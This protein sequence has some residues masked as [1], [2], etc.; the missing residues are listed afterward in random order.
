MLSGTTGRAIYTVGSMRRLLELPKKWPL[1]MMLHF[2]S[3]SAAGQKLLLGGVPVLSVTW[4]S[5]FQVLGLA[6]KKMALLVSLGALRSPASEAV[7]VPL[8]LRPGA[9]Q[10]N[11]G[12]LLTGRVT[13]W[14]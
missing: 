14:Y 9:S 12:C 1:W 7:V 13:G 5:S 8:I 2:I 3:S 6:S 4:F 10:G 11:V